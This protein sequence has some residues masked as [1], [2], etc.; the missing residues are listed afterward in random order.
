MKNPSDAN[1][2]ENLKDARGMHSDL[3]K[4]LNQLEQATSAGFVDPS[5]LDDETA[6]L[7]EN[8]ISLGRILQAAEG[9]PPAIRFSTRG[10]SVQDVSGQDHSQVKRPI[11]WR[12]MGAVL[13]IGLS[14][15]GIWFC[16]QFGLL[17]R[18]PV[19][20]PRSTN[21]VE[22]GLPPSEQSEGERVPS[23]L[24]M[25]P[26]T[27]TLLAWDDGWENQVALTASAIEQLRGPQNAHDDSMSRL[28]NM[29]LEFSLEFE[30]GSL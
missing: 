27:V 19:P 15:A 12:R 29:F 26:S 30:S 16:L 3:D 25:S 21:V 11:R 24:E 8:W 7:R 20:Q 2:E 23:N 10:V 4:L 6:M 14:L 5:S 13:A 28:Q 22:N 9:Q 1:S 18:S 17:N